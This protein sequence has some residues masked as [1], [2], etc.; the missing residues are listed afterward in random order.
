VGEGLTTIAWPDSRFFAQQGWIVVLQ[1]VL[2][3]V[4]ILVVSRHRT[5][6]N[7]S[8]RWRFLAARPLSAGVFFATIAT[9]FLYE[10]VGAP[11]TITL[12]NTMIGG[13]AFVRLSEGVLDASWKRQ[14][15][16]G[17]MLVLIVTRL[18]YVVNL[19][20]PLFRLYIL[21]AALLGL[22]FCVRWARESRCDQDSGLYPRVLRGSALVFAVIMLA[23]L[24]GKEAL[25]FYLFVSLIDSLAT[26]LVVLLFMHLIRGG[27]E[28]LIRISPLRQAAVLHR[29][30]TETII[31]QLARFINLVIWGLVVLP[32][33][34][35]IWGVYNTLKEATT[36]VLTWGVTLGSQRISVGVLIV[37]AGILYGA[38][39]LSWLLRT[40]LLD[41]LLLRRRVERGVR[42]AIERLAHYFIIAVGF[43]LALGTLG[44]ELTQ[45]TIMLSALGVGIGFGLQGVVNNFFSGLI[46]LFER[47]IRVGDAID[48]NG[49]RAEITRIGLR[50]TTVQTLD[51]TDVILPNADLISNPVTNWTL[52]S[53]R[54][55]LSIPVGVAYGSDVPL[56]MERLMTC[57]TAHEKV[58]NTPAPQVLFLG[59]GESSLDFTLHVWVVDVDDILKVKSDLHREI[60]RIF[61]EAQIEIPFPQRDLHLRSVDET[62]MGRRPEME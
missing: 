56:V 39:F 40:L 16:A 50:S 33:L 62:V 4:V 34:L 31:R 17:V 55:R 15:V 59:F 58:A 7:D 38:F 5:V 45:F 13:L 19:P 10:Y 18:L 20:I 44:V 3:V 60:D 27:V 49:N 2:V 11:E 53:R 57:A 36:G 23:E 29:E 41:R 61:R 1:G 35:T 51:Q 22:L 8:E 6:L 21:I 32:A 26:V 52:S 37:A 43:L 25:T 30:D 47:P 28:W 48:V 9:V 42:L 24:W 12:V 54:V 46:L 14:G